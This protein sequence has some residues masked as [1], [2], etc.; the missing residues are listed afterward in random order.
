ML[1]TIDYRNGNNYREKSVN[2]Q[3]R[4]VERKKQGVNNIKWTENERSIRVLKW[5][6]AESRMYECMFVSFYLWN[7]ERKTAISKAFYKYCRA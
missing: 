4:V 2:K 7:K 3:R 1:F 5:F 6:P